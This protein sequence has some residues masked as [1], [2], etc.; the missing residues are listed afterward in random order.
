MK[1]IDE[2]SIYC[3]E[4]ADVKTFMKII[5]GHDK[6]YMLNPEMMA[7]TKNIDEAFAHVAIDTALYGVVNGWDPSLYLKKNVK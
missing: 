7:L 1:I 5:N 3:T 6:R 4:I 2:I